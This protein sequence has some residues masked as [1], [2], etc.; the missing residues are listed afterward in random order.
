[1]VKRDGVA[2]DT[3]GVQAVRIYSVTV[4]LPSR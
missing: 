2:R 4:Q 1:M 3:P